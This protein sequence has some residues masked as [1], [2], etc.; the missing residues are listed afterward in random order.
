MT[1]T[2]RGI[3]SFRPVFEKHLDDWT[4]LRSSKSTRQNIYIY[5]C[6]CAPYSGSP[7]TQ[8]P[9]TIAQLPL[10]LAESAGIYSKYGTLQGYRETG[11]SL[12]ASKT[13]LRRSSCSVTPYT[14]RREKLRGQ[15]STPYPPDD[16][17]HHLKLFL[18]SSIRRV[19]I[20]DKFKSSCRLG[21]AA[22]ANKKTPNTRRP[23]CN[24]A[25]YF[26]VKSQHESYTG[27]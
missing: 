13:P 25:L 22:D 16:V 21:A 18:G 8:P 14:E 10:P 11:C 19:M 9:P 2:G 20:Q 26:H 27:K 15:L 6:A 4:G 3:P 17:Q 23:G 24:P 7:Q 12:S 1:H 5:I